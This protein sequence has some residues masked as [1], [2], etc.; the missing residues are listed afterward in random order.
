VACLRDDIRTVR[1]AKLRVAQIVDAVEGDEALISSGRLEAFRAVRALVA[2][3]P[4]TASL[5]REAADA[6]GVRNGDLIRIKE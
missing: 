6:L 1:D 5:G 3:G 2:M 4:E